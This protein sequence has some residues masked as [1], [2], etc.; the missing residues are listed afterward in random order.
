MD[1][2]KIGLRI[3]GLRSEAGLTQ[4]ALAKVLE[5]DRTTLSKIE[6]GETAPTLSVLINLKNF[7]AISFD[8]L[9]T[10]SVPREHNATTEVKELLIE[11]EKIPFLKHH[12]LS[13]FFEFKLQHPGL[14]DL[15][16]KKIIKKGKG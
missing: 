5:I 4:E 12:I 10:G 7:F 3:K 1:N 15:E 16:E 8:W 13:S 14:F 11:M 2:R 6:R 9:I